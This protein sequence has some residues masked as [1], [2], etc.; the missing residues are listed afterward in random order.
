VRPAQGDHAGLRK[1]ELA[2]DIAPVPSP[3]LNIVGFLRAELGLG[4]VA[5][6]IV[7]AV[8][9]TGLP[10][11]AVTYRRV[12]S[13]QEHPLAWRESSSAPYDT[14]IVCVNADQLPMLNHDAGPAFFR[15]RHT[16][17][18]WFWEL[19]HFPTHLHRAFALVDE[20]WVASE[21]V[22]S[23][24]A[25]ETEKP[26]HVIPLPVGDRQ[27]MESLSRDELDLPE[28][29]LFFF[30]F[31]FLSVF[32]R[33]NPLA[34]VEAFNRAFFPG[35]GP[36]LLIKSVNGDRDAQSL[37]RL[38]EAVGDRPDILV[39]DRYLSA[40]KMRGLFETC[41]CYVS[42]HRSEGFGLT[43]AEA[44]L[45]GRP[46]V[47][48]GYSGNMVFTHDRNSYLVPFR[49]A[50]VGEG[51][52]AYPPGGEWADPDVDAAGRLMRHVY[53]RPDDARRRGDLARAELV[54]TFTIERTAA[55]L[56]SRFEAIHTVG[57]PSRPGGATHAERFRQRAVRSGR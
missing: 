3:G 34:V 35:E 55:F 8:A 21:F 18:V 36:V 48:T 22:R 23:A 6:H 39:R 14:N 2:L 27:P 1:P 11:S 10:L 46:V 25:R 47:A 28:G 56:A 53:E 15:D 32:E 12:K 41:D 50:R 57:V 33:K 31:D 17:G 7:R 51:C 16:I 44:M 37:E 9:H 38:L 42:L 54:A 52:F 43:I 49:P 19:E 30:S 24:I 5:R 45:A 13:R 26:V 40:E 20:V 29:F 4:E